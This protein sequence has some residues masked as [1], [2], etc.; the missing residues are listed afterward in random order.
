M[1]EFLQTEE[2]KLKNYK[3]LNQYHLQ[4]VVFKMFVGMPK[5][6]L[7]KLKGPNKLPIKNLAHSV[8]WHHVS[9]LSAISVKQS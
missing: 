7:E 6:P 9:E 5:T 2:I 8:V 1:E 3:Q 4:N